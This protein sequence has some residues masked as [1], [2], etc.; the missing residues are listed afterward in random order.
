MAAR[1]RDRRHQSDARCRGVV[2]AGALARVAEIFARGIILSTRGLMCTISFVPTARGF[3]L[4][5]NRDEKRARVA[6]LPPAVVRLGDHRAIMPREPAGGTW[7]AVDDAG[8]CRALINWHTIEREPP[9]KIV[10]R[11]QI[12]PR[13]IGVRNSRLI[14]RELK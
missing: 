11:G 10:S 12:I 4:A 13:L 3:R 7:L 9:A 5:M 1:L 14:G 8:L 6:A 2:S